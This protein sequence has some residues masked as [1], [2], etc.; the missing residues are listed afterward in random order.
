MCSLSIFL[1]FHGVFAKQLVT[2][3]TDRSIKN[4]T[5][6]LPSRMQHAVRTAKVICPDKSMFARPWQ[7]R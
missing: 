4:G 7:L 5:A 1:P 6:H 3:V 2:H